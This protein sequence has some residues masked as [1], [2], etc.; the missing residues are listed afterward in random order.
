MIVP[1]ARGRI[2]ARALAGARRDARAAHAQLDA[3]DRDEGSSADQP[4]AITSSHT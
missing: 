1:I 3:D 4:S 2:P